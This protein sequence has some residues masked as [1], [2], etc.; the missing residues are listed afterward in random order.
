MIEQDN[1][2]VFL[3]ASLGT[4]A[5]IYLVPFQVTCSAFGAGSIPSKSLEINLQS[6]TLWVNLQSAIAL[7]ASYA[8]LIL[9]TRCGS[10]LPRIL[11]L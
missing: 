5:H 2:A 4:Y 1:N 7:G 8:Y 11:Y 6:G 9:A 10:R 3:P